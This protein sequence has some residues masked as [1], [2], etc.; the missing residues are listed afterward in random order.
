[1]G[2]YTWLSDQEFE[3]YS[4]VEDQIVNEAFQEVRALM[5]NWFIYEKQW[6]KKSFFGKSTAGYTYTVYQR[7]KEDYREVRIQMSAS[8]PATVC[9]LLYGLYMGYKTNK[10]DTLFNM[11]Y[12]SYE[13]LKK[14]NNRLQLENTNLK[15]ELL[16]ALKK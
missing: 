3:R 15:G 1:M 7:Q 14:E 2:V 13:E 6:I 5:P 10:D 16:K 8:S 12:E 9:N 4:Q 11:L